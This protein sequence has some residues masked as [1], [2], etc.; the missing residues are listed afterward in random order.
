[1]GVGLVDK[2]GREGHEDDAKVAAGERDDGAGWKV[3]ERGE[4]SSSSE[5]SLSEAETF[6]SSEV[7]V[8]AACSIG[9]SLLSKATDV[10]GESLLS[11]NAEPEAMDSRGSSS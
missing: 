9:V 2:G 8:D 7:E 6:S 1:M 5:D 4:L 3:T 10:R 11:C